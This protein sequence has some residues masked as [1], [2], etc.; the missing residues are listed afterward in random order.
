LPSKETVFY[1][2]DN[3]CWNISSLDSQDGYYKLAQLVRANKALADYCLAFNIPCISGKDS[4]KNVWKMKEVVDGKEVEKTV[5]IPPTLMFSARAKI[6]DVRKAV[7]MDVKR[8]GDLVYVVGETFDELG[9][10]EY[11]AY[12]SEEERRERYVGCKVP[13]VDA[14]RA[15]RIYRSI[16]EATEKEILHSAHTPT[17]GGLGIALAQSAFA[18]GYGMEIDLRKVPYSGEK[19]DD[20]ILFSESNSRFAVTVPPERKEVFEKIM[21]GNVYS[22]IGIVTGDNRLKI[23]GLNGK[24]LIDS[25]LD[26]LRAVWK[27]TLGG[28]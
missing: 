7:T 6:K 22:E 16:S 2:L 5:S 8:I 10:S 19:R 15:K 11:Y 21:D 12:M 26:H 14:E 25:N 1:G 17:I 18:G 27:K 28:L 24:P 23:K 13:K 3:F 9:G 20:Y 4:M